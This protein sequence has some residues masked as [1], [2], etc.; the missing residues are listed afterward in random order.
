M[1]HI[2]TTLIFAL[3]CSVTL[4]CGRSNSLIP[5]PETGTESVLDIDSSQQNSDARTTALEREPDESVGLVIGGVRPRVII[6][7]EE[8]QELLLPVP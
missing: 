6:Q 4:G 1:T 2:N 7:P 3:A 5:S 8:P